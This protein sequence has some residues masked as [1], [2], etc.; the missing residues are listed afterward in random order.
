MECYFIDRFDED[1]S[2]VGGLV[3]WRGDFGLDTLLDV[4]FRMF[5]CFD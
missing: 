4:V 1:W 5:G 2:I 3:F